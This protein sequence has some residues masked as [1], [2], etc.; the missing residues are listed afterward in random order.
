MASVPAALLRRKSTFLFLR[1]KLMDSL[2]LSLL[3]V[4][5][6]HLFQVEQSVPFFQLYFQRHHLQGH[7]DQQ[8]AGWMSVSEF[9]KNQMLKLLVWL[10]PCPAF[11]LG[12]S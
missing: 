7:T 3:P 8:T 1:L 4:Q 11:L 10:R 9:L 6:H 2:Y 5:P 12:G